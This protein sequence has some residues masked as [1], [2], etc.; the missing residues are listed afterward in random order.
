MQIP[1]NAQLYFT[2]SHF[3]LHSGNG[4]WAVKKYHA[5]GYKAL[6]SFVFV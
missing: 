5:K 2:F 4:N 6:C 3:Y 1:P